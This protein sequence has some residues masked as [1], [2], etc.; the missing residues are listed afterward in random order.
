MLRD[1]GDGMRCPLGTDV[2]ESEC[3]EAANTFSSIADTSEGIHRSDGYDFTPCGCYLWKNPEE[4]NWNPN[5][6]R[7]QNGCQSDENHS[8]LICKRKKIDTESC[9][10]LD[11]HI[12]Y[13]GKINITVG[14]YQCQRWDLQS[15]HEHTFTPDEY[16][17]S[18]LEENYCR[19]PG[20][21]GE[22]AWCYTTDAGERWEYCD[23]PSC[24]ESVLDEFDFYPL[25]DSPGND[26][27][28]KRSGGI[29][30][31]AKECIEKDNCL[32]FNSNGWL[33]DTIQIKSQWYKW[34][35]NPSQGIYV[36]K[37]Y[38]F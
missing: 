10:N 9:S 38:K 17:N 22:K 2:P 1:V 32:G 12:D 14:G 31:Y 35:D 16:P 4:N 26:I 5:Y 25:M 23:V 7:G 6:D 29:E 19:N 34:T 18:G 28:N 36:K 11:N 13:R 33:K 30:D 3:L 8:R 27:G 15:P 37:S 24:S 20:A 21:S